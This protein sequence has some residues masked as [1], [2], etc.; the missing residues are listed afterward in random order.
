MKSTIITQ[1]AFALGCAAL[2]GASTLYAQ[3]GATAEE[4][5]SLFALIGE[6]GWAMIPLGLCSIFM[7]FLIF[8][9]WKETVRKKFIPEGMITQASSYL[10]ARQVSEA[11]MALQESDSVLSRALVPALSKARPERHDANRAKVE[12]IL[13]ENLESE[14]NAVGQW[15][16]YLNVV[17][18]VAPMIGLL[19]TVSGM[20]SAFQTIGTGGMGRP[21]L[22]AGSIGEALITTATG[23]VIGIPS[24]VFYF[25]MKNRLGNQMI[26]T[27]QTASNLID[28]LAEESEYVTE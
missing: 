21:E 9:C 3:E 23:L 10:Q 26:A 7:F 28:V 22:L 20:I 2:V 18:T 17:A 14:E 16:N 25:V 11:Q 12:T 19:G 4:G 15:V 1:R 27:V 8:Y 6:G 24:M 13:V 5:K